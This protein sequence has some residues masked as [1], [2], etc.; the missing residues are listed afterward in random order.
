MRTTL[1]LD[2]DNAVRLERLRKECDLGL[3]EIVNEAIRLGLNEMA[4]PTRKRQPF[5]TRA[6]SMGPLLFPTVK[7]ALRVLEEDLDHKKLGT[8]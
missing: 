2:D 5:R 4:Q 6:V 7:E 3:K 8:E 1:T